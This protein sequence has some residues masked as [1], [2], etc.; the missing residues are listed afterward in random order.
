MATELEKMFLAILAQDKQIHERLDGL[1]RVIGTC[2]DDNTLLRR[3]IQVLLRGG[4]ASEL[5]EQAAI[6]DPGG[7][8]KRQARKRVRL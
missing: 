6:P 8:K 7:V 5:M 2:H 3:I 4:D 1:E